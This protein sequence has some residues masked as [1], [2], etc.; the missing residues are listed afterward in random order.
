[1]LKVI[2]SRIHNLF[3]PLIFW[4]LGI[5]LATKL[6]Y[7]W[8]LHLVALVCLISFHLFRKLRF[9]LILLLFTLLAWLYTSSFLGESSQDISYYLRQTEV[10]SEMFEYKVENIKRTS[11]GSSYYIISL[12]KLN[13]FQIK[14]ELLL[15]SRIDSL[16]INNIY[17]SNLQVFPIDKVKNPGEFDY[18]KFYNYQGIRGRAFTNGLTKHIA[19]EENL[20]QALK[21]HIVTKIQSIYTAKSPLALA[22]FIGDKAMLNIEQDKLS[23]MGLIHIFAVSGLHVG[24][25]YLS[26]LT[27]I[28]LF[29]NQNKSRI[30]ASLLLIFYGFL[31]SWSPSVSR[32]VL[33]ILIYNLALVFQRKI[34]FL[35]IISISLF[36]ITI[37]NPLQVFS[38]G[39]QLSLTAFIALWIADR[40]FM[41]YY[42]KSIRKYSVPKY[43]SRLVQYLVFTLSIIIFISPLSAYSFN[44]ITFNA[45]LTNVLATP[46]VTLML[47]VILLSLFLPQNLFVQDYLAAAFTLLA[48]AFEELVVL[49][50][51]LPFFTRNISL[52][53]IEFLIILISL[54]LIYLLH[55]KKK[56]LAYLLSF[57][58]T[59]LLM[60]RVLGFFTFYHN[61]VICFAAGNADCSY[62][63]FADGLNLVI[64]TGSQE[65]NPVIVK[66]ALIPYLKKRHIT[67]LACVMITHPHED[68]Y[69]GLPLLADNI[70]ID[71]IIIHESALNDAKF[72]TIINELPT[73][74]KV[75]VL[76]DTMSFWNRRVNILHPTKDYKSENMNN[77]SLVAMINYADKKLLFTGD[78]EED[79]EKH[80]IKVYHNELNADFLKVP[81]HGSITSSS[82][83]FLQEVAAS[84]SYIPAG[85]RDREHFPNKLILERLKALESMIHNGNEDG[86]LEMNFGN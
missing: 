57:T 83:D 35:Q 75:V 77:N 52:T 36:I 10:I 85:N 78:I 27:L 3:I 12:K 81:H 56:L 17:Q 40:V 41:P 80:L 45:I 13:N 29:L 11:K 30:I 20:L 82:W 28:N 21:S 53:G 43:I 76:T 71:Q 86:A 70:K 18:H 84:Q 9:F 22:L 19:Q 33:I 62:L 46:L 15:Y 23:Q 37:S 48:R 42:Y 60:A 24:I 6:N 34:S 64:D 2:R 58:L 32:T 47:N 25:I 1:M 16:Q 61:Q 66:T 65:Q 44:I 73:E 69:G 5:L 50:E 68:H 79:A 54:S 26:L 51:K 74:I 38:V 72:S 8:T 4:I 63:E 7:H 55:K 39:L 49:A 59:L 31:C 67:S 14:G